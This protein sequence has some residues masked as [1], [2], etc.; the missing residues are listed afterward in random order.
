MPP[1][2]ETERRSDF[3]AVGLLLYFYVKENPEDP[4][5]D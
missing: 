5:R 2:N 3:A 4:F 1:D